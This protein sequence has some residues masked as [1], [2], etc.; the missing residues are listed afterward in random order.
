[1]NKENLTRVFFHE[2]GHFIA[3]ELSYKLFNI[4]LGT[5]HIWI[6]PYKLNNYIDYGGGTK[7]KKPKDY[8]PRKKGDIE[9]P[10]HFMAGI[11]YGCLI[12][13]IYLKSITNYNFSKCFS[14]D[15]EANG[16]HDVIDFATTHLYFNGKK[17]KK[18]LDF[19][20]NKYI[21]QLNSDKVH[22][23]KLFKFSPLDFA[24]DFSSEQFLDMELIR[25]SLKDFL[26]EHEVHYSFLIKNIEII[27]NENN[28]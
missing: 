21:D 16:K 14:F 4:G 5:E 24:Y 27:K 8:I 28:T 23:E 25:K 15:E 2:I 10:V 12:Q 6:K 3:F 19:I 9:N 1:M 26:I 18:I 20:N 13:T 22:L 17:R 11:L 7:P